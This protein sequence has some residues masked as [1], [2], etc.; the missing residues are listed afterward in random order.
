MIGVGK[1]RQIA[2][3]ILEHKLTG[4]KR[5]L[6]ISVS[7]DLRYDAVRDLGDVNARH[8]K[9]WPEVNVCRIPAPWPLVSGAA[10]LPGGVSFTFLRTS[11]WLCPRSRG[12]MQCTL[13]LQ[14]NTTIP[15][16]RIE[17][18]FRQGV[19]FVTY[20]LLVSNAKSMGNETADGSSDAQIDAKIPAGSR[21]EQIVDWLKG[22]ENPLVILDE[23]HKAK[24]LVASGGMLSRCFAR[25]YI[26]DSFKVLWGSSP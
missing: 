14:G 6:W 13:H 4:G 18:S 17:K 22:D 8:I 9:V 16:G 1:G 26:C 23:C 25:D 24:N 3:L 15:K 19:L 12:L 2:G 21:L 7:N 5:C 11:F 10:V 20:S